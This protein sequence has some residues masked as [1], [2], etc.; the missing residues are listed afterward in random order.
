MATYKLT[1][2]YDGTAYA[3]WQRQLNQPTIQAAIETALHQITQATISVIGAGR[4]DAGVHAWGQVASFR[5]EKPLTVDDWHRALNGLLP[6]DISVRS[7]QQVSDDFHARFSARAKLYEYRILNRPEPPALDRHRVW[8][9]R[10][11]LDIPA[12]QQ[13]ANVLL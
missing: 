6:D 13:A 4:T 8:H 7:V 11:L 12:M 5:S 10:T 9:I 2:E 1:V 3:G